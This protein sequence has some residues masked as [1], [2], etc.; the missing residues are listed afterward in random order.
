MISKP[1]TYDCLRTVLSYIEPNKRIQCAIQISSIRKLEKTLPLRIRKLSFSENF[2]VI[3][4]TEYLFGVFRHYDSQE[5]PQFIQSQNEKGGCKYDIDKYGFEDKDTWNKPMPGDIVMNAQEVEEPRRDINTI[6]VR[7]QE[8]RELEME[9][10]GL[11]NKITLWQAQKEYISEEQAV[12][13]R[14]NAIQAKWQ[15]DQKMEEIERAHYEIQCYK[16][17]RDNTPPPFE[18]FIQLR[19][20]DEETRFDATFTNQKFERLVCNKTLP[21]AMRAVLKLIFENRQHPVQVTKTDVDQDH[22]LRLPSDFKMN[23]RCLSVRGVL[24]KVCDPLSSIIDAA[25]LPLEKVY[26]ESDAGFINDFQPELARTAKKLIIG[27]HWDI[28]IEWLPV[29]RTLQNQYVKMLD[30]TLPAA[31]FIELIRSWLQEGKR[32]G[33]TFIFCG[34]T[35]PPTE[36][37]EAAEQQFPRTHREDR[38]ITIPMTSFS[39]IQVSHYRNDGILEMK[40]LSVESIEVSVVTE[41]FYSTS[42]N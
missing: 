42:I 28:D 8:I 29:F 34:Q 4:Q 25:C 23:L 1:M 16:C 18:S 32:V 31:D 27:N 21:D 37:F 17:F 2:F 5:T 15:I 9:L 40:V 22:I 14:S 26:V 41:K 7:E 19:L 36:L 11:H 24:G 10:P 3:N 39:K 6:R 12:L 30:D 20:C 13:L 33:T 35:Q 38:S